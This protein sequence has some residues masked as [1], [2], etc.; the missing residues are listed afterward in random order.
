MRRR[1]FPRH[2]TQH[3]EVRCLPCEFA[4]F[5]FVGADLLLLAARSRR[6]RRREPLAKP[7]HQRVEQDDDV[8]AREAPRASRRGLPPGSR[9]R[10][11]CRSL[12][13]LVVR[14]GRCRRTER[15]RAHHV[16]RVEDDLLR[17]LQQ[18]L[19]LRRI[20]FER[21]ERLPERLARIAAEVLRDVLGAVNDD[22][23]VTIGRTLLEVAGA[24]A[25]GVGRIDNARLT[26]DGITE[27]C[28]HIAGTAKDQADSQRLLRQEPGRRRRSDADVPRLLGDRGRCGLPACGDGVP[29]G[30][31]DGW[32][33]E[34]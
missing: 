11:R 9:K 15:R 14:T 18:R 13:C 22:E 19:E 21:T 10:E 6:R 24:V 3:L 16:V 30:G 25:H 29:V 1:T 4:A 32:R 33:A 7:T 20:F 23:R 5:L 31:S 12:A 34:Q 26:H 27:G 17:Q 8:T 2:A 28:V